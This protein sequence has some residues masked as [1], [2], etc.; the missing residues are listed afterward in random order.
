MPPSPSA[1][2]IRPLSATLF[3]IALAAAFWRIPNPPPAQ[4]E[5][6]AAQA[7]TGTAYHVNALVPGTGNAREISLTQ[8]GDGR[9]GLAWRIDEAGAAIRFSTLGKEGW[10]PARQIASRESAAGGTLAYVSR[11]GAPVLLGEGG[12]LHLWFAGYALDLDGRGAL[13]YSRSTDG[14]QTWTPPHK[15]AASPLG[16]AGLLPHAAPLPLADGGYGLAVTQDL[17]TTRAAWLRLGPDGRVLDRLRMPADTAGGLPGVAPL[18]ETRGLAVLTADEPGAGGPTVVS[19]ENGSQF[20]QAGRITLPPLNA[21]TP[22]A[23]LRLKS[24]R[25]LLA[26]NP[27]DARGVLQLWLTDDQGKSWRL[28][29]TVESSADG[30]ADFSRPALLLAR[31]GRIHLAYTWR[32]QGIRL[33]SFNEA[34]LDGGDA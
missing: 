6:P 8:L 30:A 24:G 29:R 13:H 19:T 34:W 1:P 5:A 20:W 27:P 9:L 15:L 22:P 7:S 23:L 16:N 3:G 14:G 21:Q 10:T 12:W 4:F 18:S 33:Q 32:Q 11:L 31:D 17:L 26:G 2:S 28:V 25:L